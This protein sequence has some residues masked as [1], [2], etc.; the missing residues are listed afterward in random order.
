MNN[1]REICKAIK[2]LNVYKNIVIVGHI[3]PDLDSICSCAL[4]Q[5]ILKIHNIE[6][7]ILLE[8]KYLELLDWYS[9]KSDL[10]FEEKIPRNIDVCIMLDSR[11][12]DR[13]GIYEKAFNNSKVKLNIDHHE[14]NKRQADYFYV[15]SEISSTCELI[16]DILNYMRIP[17]TKDLAELM[18]AGIIS[19]TESFSKRTT[20]NTFSIAA[21]LLEIKIDS[22]DIIRK[23]YLQKSL[24]DMEILSNLINDIKFDKFHYIV[25]DINDEKY[26]NY[27][28]NLVSKKLLPILQSIKEVKCLGFFVK[29]KKY[30]KCEFRSNV[31]DIDV[32]KIAELF[33]G[34]GHKG[35]SGAT[36]YLEIDEILDMVKKCF[37]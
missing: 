26:K 23:V 32:S 1:L 9:G 18:Y 20:S 35:A 34:G 5:K 21:S 33:G 3:N 13:L 8:S 27:S 4:L 7:K 29:H 6:S 16:Y 14:N 22:S 15:K 19:D 28:Y 24:E 31:S 2:N 30:V 11:S 37:D 17:I 25:I 12:S 36:S 10:N